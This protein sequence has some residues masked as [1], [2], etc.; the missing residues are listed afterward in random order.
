MSK[1]NEYLIED[2]SYSIFNIKKLEIYG[3]RIFEIN[4]VIKK[5]NNAVKEFLSITKDVDYL[6]VYYYPT[7]KDL[8]SN[9]ALCHLVLTEN[10]KNIDLSDNKICENIRWNKEYDSFDGFVKEKHHPIIRS[11]RK[12]IRCMDFLYKIRRIKSEVWEIW[13]RSW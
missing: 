12:L 5:T 3:H 13:K 6:I 2:L 1:Y 7:W 9:M 8:E 11:L 4:E 10:I